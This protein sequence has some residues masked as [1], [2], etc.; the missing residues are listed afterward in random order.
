VAGTVAY[1]QPAGLSGTAA[2][3]LRLSDSLELRPEHFVLLEGVPTHQS[4]ARRLVIKRNRVFEVRVVFG[5][6]NPTASL[7]AKINGVLRSLEID[8]GSAHKREDG[9]GRSVR[10]PIPTG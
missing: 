9:N 8:E 4:A 5:S 1:H 6:A 3:R 10:V 2:E 7:I